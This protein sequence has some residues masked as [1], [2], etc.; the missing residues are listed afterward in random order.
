MDEKKPIINLNI[1]LFKENVKN[2]TDAY[3]KGSDI[4][5]VNI[6][7]GIKYEGIVVYSK[8]KH[9]QP[10]WK[11][12]VDEISESKIDLSANTSNKAAIIVKIRSRFMAVVLGYGKSLL[13]A[14]KFER[15]FGLKAALN[16][17]E[18][19]QMRSIQSAAIEDMI[20]STH[21]Q[22]S[23]LTSQEEFDLN[24]YSDIIRSI[25]G[26]PY[27][28]DF[29]TAISGKDTLSVAV[30]MDINELGEKLEKYLNVYQNDRYKKIGFKWVDNINEIRDTELKQ[31]L[32]IF[33][34][35]KLIKK[36]I[37]NMYIAPPDIIDIESIEGYCFSGIGKDLKNISNYSFEPS[38]IEY[39]EKLTTN[40]HQK[41]IDKIRRDKLMA[42]DL[43]GA[44]NSICNIF[45][46][47]VWECCFLKKTYI[48]WDG[49]WYYVEKDYLKEVNNFINKIPICSQTLPNCNYGESEGEYN[50]RVAQNNSTICLMDKKLIRVRGS[51]KQIESCDLFTQN[52]ML[53]HIKKRASSSQLSHLFSQGR[54]SAE[55]FLSDETFRNQ[56]F[57][58]VKDKLGNEV[59][60]YIDEP[61]SNEYEVVYAIIAKKHDCLVEKLPFFSKVNLMLTCQ[62]LERTRFGYSI[63]FIE[64]NEAG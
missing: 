11:A 43:N 10:K 34:V 1:V 38:L 13:R 31:K 52:K 9:T 30:S 26:K 33:L 18:E 5:I 19:K 44:Y 40:D 17:I 64:Q 50:E 46:S 63:C 49:S 59:F 20:V 35:E 60:N 25:N 16:M 51:A 24:T 48:L 45:S 8:S 61:R 56:V 4:N 15:N 12:L 54:V 14:D 57:N 21:R 3:E 47:I 41:I 27:D 42:I 2:Y 37:Q 7:D 6:R 55:C 58:L 62:S 22:A 32:N 29:G 39:I 28:E 36:E 23:R 53:I